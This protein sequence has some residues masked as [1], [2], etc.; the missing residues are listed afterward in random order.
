MEVTRLTKKRIAEYL[1]QGKRFD[2]RTAQ[3]FRDITITLGASNMAEGSATVKLGKTEVIAGVKMNVGTP[4]PNEEESGTMSVGMELLPLSSNR[5]E[6]GPPKFD[7]TEIGRLIDR[8]LRDSGM[9]DFK[10]LCIKVGEKVWMINI[11]IYS[12]NDDGNLLDAAG[13]AAIA[14]LR[15]AK[16]PKYDET[17]GRVQFGE[18]TDNALPLDLSVMPI[19]VTFHKIGDKFLVDPSA[20]EE[21]SSDSRMAIGLSE[22]Q[23]KV[24]INSIQ[25]SESAEMSINEV[26]QV[27][28]MAEE[29]FKNLKIKVEK[30]LKEKK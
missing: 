21:D 8:G 12:I 15:S 18:W 1:L 24:M 25:K 10:K 14:A 26:E 28:D 3:E 20:I 17:T 4:Y 22:Y 23:G 6:A 11:D 30:A 7:A 29:A 9:I 5:Y 19:N 16:M 13:I 2:G 27:L